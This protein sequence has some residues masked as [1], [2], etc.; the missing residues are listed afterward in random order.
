MPARTP[1][2]WVGAS[3]ALL[4]GA[5]ALGMRF[6][7]RDPPGSVSV[8]DPGPALLVDDSRMEER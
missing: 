1:R 8:P 4:C 2:L 6:A 5:P 3:I 7:G